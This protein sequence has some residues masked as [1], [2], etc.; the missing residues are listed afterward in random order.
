MG[1]KTRR[2]TRRRGTGA[3]RPSHLGTA[4]PNLLLLRDGQVGRPSIDDGVDEAQ[5]FPVDAEEDIFGVQVFDED[6]LGWEVVVVVAEAEGTEAGHEGLNLGA[7]G[8]NEIAICIGG[9]IGFRLGNHHVQMVAIFEEANDLVGGIGE[10]EMMVVKPVQILLPV[11]M[12]AAIIGLDVF[13][14][15]GWIDSLLGSS[16]RACGEPLFV[17]VCGVDE[18]MG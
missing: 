12:V 1:G 7:G 13:A 15:A 4:R 11:S 18:K 16:E 10:E 9:G 17:K 3:R 8:S 6:V 2:E 5:G 14:V